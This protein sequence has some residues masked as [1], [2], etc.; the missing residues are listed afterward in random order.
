MG[1]RSSGGLLGYLLV[2]AGKP[3]PDEDRFLVYALAQ[4]TG[5]ALY[6]AEARRRD[7]E[8]ARQL[9]RAIEERDAVNERLTALVAELEE[10]RTVHDVL[11]RTSLTDEGGA[12][13]RRRRVRADRPRHPCRGPLRKPPR[14]RGAG[15]ARARHQA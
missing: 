7:R 11:A 6:N 1:L 9:F 12:R 14:P 2:S 10:Q 8:Y 13:H 4:P 5:A 15:P 3:P